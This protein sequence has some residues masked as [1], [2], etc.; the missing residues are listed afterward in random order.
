MLNNKLHQHRVVI[1]MPS[2]TSRTHGFETS[3]FRDFKGSDLPTKTKSKAQKLRDLERRKTFL[4]RKTVCS[5]LPCSELSDKEFRKLF[6]R[7]ASHP[8]LPVA[9][10]NTLVCSLRLAEAK[11]SK[12]QNEM[13]EL[14]STHI[15]VQQRHS[16]EMD[17]SKET[18]SFHN[19][20]NEL[21]HLKIADLEQRNKQLQEGF[22][23]VNAA[24]NRLHE[25]KEQLTTVIQSCL[26]NL[27][28][29][30]QRTVD[31]TVTSTPYVREPNGSVNKGQN[32]NGKTD[33]L[34]PPSD[35]EPSCEWCSVVGAFYRVC[36]PT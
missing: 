35:G 29:Y 4:E 27:D 18:L 6:S 16:E 22:N 7:P 14:K 20:N 2:R 1:E 11:I 12:L 24:C 36:M 21:L 15:L 13:E 9:V 33:F 31:G 23:L 10:N 25:D 30:K 32:S 26:E 5:L 19:F 8:D 17:Q 3:K 34:Q 28:S